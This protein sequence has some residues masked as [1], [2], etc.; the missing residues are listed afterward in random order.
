MI[1]MKLDMNESIIR[2]S[3]EAIPVAIS[4][5]INKT[6]PQARTQLAKEV[7]QDWNIKAGAFKKAAKIVQKSNTRTLTSIIK[8]K[9]SP[10]PVIKF[11]GT[12]QNAKGV[13]VNIKKATGAKTITHGFVTVMK[14]GHKGAFIRRRKGEALARA[15]RNTKGSRIV[16]GINAR[17]NSGLMGR[18]PVKELVGP[19]IPQMIDDN[20]FEDINKWGNDKLRKNYDIALS[21]E[22]R[23][24]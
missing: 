18:L 21:N 11:T 6:M 9:G 7:R 19:S 24:G 13:R 8:A 12:R 2:K 17:G 15:S 5:A 22:W 4:R 10:I 1:S 3:I 16:G 23:R 20:I 14:T